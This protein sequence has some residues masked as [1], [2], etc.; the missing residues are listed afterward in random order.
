MAEEFVPDEITSARHTVSLCS[1]PEIPI[2]TGQHG[3]TVQ[4]RSIFAVRACCAGDGREG[5][6]ES[7]LAPP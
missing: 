2:G 7:K 3:R 1:S 5:D 6:P 4:W